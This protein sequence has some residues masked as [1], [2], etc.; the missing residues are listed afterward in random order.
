MTDIKAGRAVAYSVV[1]TALLRVFVVLFLAFSMGYVAT[2]NMAQA[3]TY[4]FSQVKI[5]GNQRIEPATILTYAGIARG[6]TVS[7]AQLN[8]AYQRILNSGLFES[9]SVEPRGGTL[10]IKVKEFPT[11]NRISFEGNKRLKDKDLAQIIRSQSR[12]VYSPSTA[13]ADAAVLTEAYSQQGRY[14]ATVTP[15]II[16]RSENRVDLVFEIVEGKVVE[17]ERLSFV[18]NRA[19]SDRRLR[20]VLETKQAGIFRAIIQKDTFIADRVEFD[21][22]VLRDF[23]LSR[24]YIDFR[25][26]SVNSEIARERNGFF[27]TFNVREGQRFKFGEISAVS[28]LPSVDAEEFMRAVK[29]KSGKTYTPVAVETTIARM[30]RL[31]IQKGMNFI[32]VEPRV[33]RNDRDLTLDIEF[34]ISRGPRIFVERIDIEGNATTLDRVIR[35]QFKVVEGDPFNPRQIREAA[36]RIRNLGFF[37]KADVNAREGTGPDQ[38]IV[39]VNVAEQPTGSL[40]LGASYGTDGGLGFSIGFK[41]SN[42]LGRGQGFNF[43]LNTAS[44]TNSV[45]FSFVEPALLGRNVRLRFSGS[46]ATTEGFNSTFDTRKANFG[47]GLEFPVSEN[48][49]LELRYQIGSDKIFNLAIPV[50]PLVISPILQAEEAEGTVIT[51]QLGYGFSYDTRRTGL[52]PNAGIVLRF[53]QDFAGL[54]GDSQFIKTTAL[55]GAETKVYNEEVTLR[56]VFEG[57]AIASLSGTNS[58]VNN[59]FFL[60]GSKMRGF[61]SLGIGPRNGNDINGNALGGNMFAVARFDAEFPLGLPEEYGIRGGL[62]LDVGSVWGL[63]NTYG[64]GVDDTLHWRSSIGF[65]IL[66]TT[67]IGPLRFNFSKALQKEDYDRDR[68]FELTIQTKF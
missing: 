11:I 40:D 48:G 65:S 47:I 42:F 13:E 28:D 37:S 33:T 9:V 66:W 2:P 55:I 59:R 60:N 41:E 54:G 58:R 17:I 21:K 56:A 19:F 26:L 27:L 53:G 51:S 12:H 62:F 46:Y 57:G 25:V 5:E 18:G 20:R 4:R 68:S 67:G 50:A 43:S 30:E 10:V 49:R 29:I 44:E 35:R 1:K 7:A 52:N 8:D 15:K 45:S 23:Y 39:D 64:S 63:D 6:E 36:E 3:Q 34:V 32:R 38:V 61:E 24:G 31:A 14:S 16:R 22:Q